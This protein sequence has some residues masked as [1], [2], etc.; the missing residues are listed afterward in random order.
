MDAI[1]AINNQI[2]IL[3]SL[4]LG[5]L[6]NL[7]NMI[8]DKWKPKKVLIAADND[9]EENLPSVILELENFLR[10]RDIEVEICVPQLEKG[11]KC[12]SNDMLKAHGTEHMKN[13]FA[14]I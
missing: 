7:Q 1:D 2:P 3:A 8:A 6:Q 14:K 9:N 10:K 5:N 12:D 11:V 13:I 4:S